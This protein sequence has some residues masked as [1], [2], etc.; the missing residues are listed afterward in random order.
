MSKRES[1]FNLSSSSSGGTTTE[2]HSNFRQVYVPFKQRIPT[3]KSQFTVNVPHIY[4]DREFFFSSL[5][6]LPDFYSKEAQAENLDDDEVLA[7]PIDYE[8]FFKIIFAN[9]P[10]FY[11][12]TFIAGREVTTTSQLVTAINQFFEIHKSAA[13]TRLGCFLDWTDLRYTGDITW[14]DWVQKIMAFAYYEEEYDP[15][16]HFN[17]LPVSARTVRGANNYLVPTNMTH[18]N[19]SKFR[20]RIVLAPNTTASFS[21]N[22]PLL[23]LGFSDSQIGKRTTKNK[24]TME[25]DENSIFEFITA[26]LSQS[27]TLDKTNPFKM[28]LDVYNEDYVSDSSLITIT[29]GESVKNENYLKVIKKSL[30]VISYESNV[31]IDVGYDKGEK[32]F[33][34]T[35]PQDRA[36]HLSSLLVPKDLSERIGFDLVTEIN[37]NNK[38]GKP[39]PED[40]DVKNTEEKARALGY[41]TGVVIVSNANIRSNTTAGINEEFMCSLYPTATG[42][43][44]IPTVESCYRPATTKLPHFYTSSTGVVPA[45]FKLSRYLDNDQLVHLDWKNGAFV[46]GILRGSKPKIYK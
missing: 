46:S 33:T 1:N 31:K 24:F 9:T 38:T 14:D 36:I 4:T 26:K 13:A 17:A 34:F 37:P 12:D 22:G 6:L 44:E 2:D 43:F 3:G 5:V 41:D 23:N 20:F 35:F 42:T 15:N 8:I 40:I 27:V 29:K 11:P 7:T 30:D 32:T 25:N 19:L 16:K 28:N 18:E 21:T 39:V 10:S 45:V